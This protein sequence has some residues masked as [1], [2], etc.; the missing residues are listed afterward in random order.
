M[1]VQ[2]EY[3]RDA[4]GHVADVRGGIEW[5][6]R[7]VNGVW[8]RG[9][10]WNV[11]P[12]CM[13]DCTWKMPDGS[14]AQ[15]YAKT[16][17][18]GVAKEA[19]PDGFAHPYWHPERLEEPLRVK[20]PASIFPDSMGDLMGR[21]MH[22]QQIQAVLDTMRKAYWHRFMLLTKNAPRLLQFDFPPNVWVGVS[23]PPSTMFGRSLDE[24]QQ[25]AM[26]RRQ[27]DVLRQVKTPVRWMSIEP[28]SFDIAPLLVDAPLNWAVIGAA[29]KGAVT[30]QPEP[31]WVHNAIDVLHR[32][33]TAVFFKGNMKGNQAAD[34]WLEEFPEETR[35]ATFQEALFE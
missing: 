23:A 1:N 27:V 4:N 30:Y 24:N 6:K 14:I 9:Y 7:K 15:C 25:A 16:V 20:L 35:L 18:E 28:L 33:G 21:W 31:Q 29:T 22:N 11:A 26:I 34:P 12:G 2:G 10:T 32:G 8:R 19:Y 5:L 13:H 3:I 17:A